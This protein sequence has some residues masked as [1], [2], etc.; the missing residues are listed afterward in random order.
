ME[1]GE[2]A[3]AQPEANGDAESVRAGHVVARRAQPSP[4]ATTQVGVLQT[5]FSVK[6]HDRRTTKGRGRDAVGEPLRGESARRS[7]SIAHLAEA[8]DATA[9]NGFGERR[10]GGHHLSS[11]QQLGGERFVFSPDVEDQPLVDL[12]ECRQEPGRQAVRIRGQGNHLGAGAAV[13]LELAHRLARDHLD[14]AGGAQQHLARRSRPDRFGADEQHPTCRAL[15]R[16]DPLAHCQRR[17]MQL[18]SG[19]LEG[20]LSDGDRE[21]GELVRVEDGH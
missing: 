12:R 17:E 18:V 20:A 14:L 1:V 4:G 11:A 21:R 9:R 15:E 10:D 8:L 3:P 13:A 5:I 2:H 6:D 7:W 19:R 16:L